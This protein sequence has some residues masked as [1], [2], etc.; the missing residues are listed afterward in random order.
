MMIFTDNHLSDIQNACKEWQQLLVD[1]NL[2]KSELT[3]DE[4]EYLKILITQ[5]LVINSHDHGS[6]GLYSVPNM[7]FV[8]F[9]HNLQI[10]LSRRQKVLASFEKLVEQNGPVLQKLSEN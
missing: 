10:K 3:K 5:D 2:R 9:V 1:D 6:E 8:D 7:N 4:I